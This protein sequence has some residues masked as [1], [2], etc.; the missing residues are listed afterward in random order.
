MAADL[1]K[2]LEKCEANAQ[3]LVEEIKQYKTARQLNQRVVEQL[4]AVVESLRKVSIEIKP[5]TEAHVRRFMVVMSVA[6]FV[7]AAL[8]G[9]LVFM[10]F[11]KHL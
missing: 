2:S 6:W 5:F 1:H 7:I 8:L 4:D 10:L 11:R 3:A 9:V